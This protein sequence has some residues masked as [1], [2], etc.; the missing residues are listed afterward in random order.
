MGFDSYAQETANRGISSTA[1]HV[2][3]A[4][5]TGVILDGDVVPATDINTGDQTFWDEGKTR[6]KKQ[7]VMTL[8]LSNESPNPCKCGQPNYHPDR[9]GQ[10]VEGTRRRFRMTIGS[11][12]EKEF[13][14][15]LRASGAKVP[16]E[17]ATLTVT[18]TQYE[19]K[20]TG[21]FY[22][23][24]YD[25]S[26]ISPTA[27]S[28]AVYAAYLAETKPSSMPTQADYASLLSEVDTRQVSPDV[29]SFEDLEKIT[30]EKA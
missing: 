27:E 24:L 2:E 18:F 3:G 8:E 20:K 6:P 9:Y 16:E 25:V 10:K 12:L 29:L 19:T 28:K 15:A 30:G 17:G 7:L 11:A 23:K 4:T 14:K 22:K 5:F 13:S 1:L 21:N 26:Y